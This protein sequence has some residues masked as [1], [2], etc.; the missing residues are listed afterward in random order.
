MMGLQVN[1]KF[2]NDLMSRCQNCSFPHTCAHTS[3]GCSSFSTSQFWKHPVSCQV[4]PKIFLLVFSRAGGSINNSVNDSK[5]TLMQG[6]I[7]AKFA[8]PRLM[9]AHFISALLGIPV[10]MKWSKFHIPLVLNTQTSRHWGE[11]QNANSNYP[12]CSWQY[13]AAAN[14]AKWK[15]KK[16]G[17]LFI[18]NPIYSRRRRKL[19]DLTMRSP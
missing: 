13:L 15:G 3:L 11:G 10:R 9:G 16:G 6:R 19:Q 12:S 14:I 5:K 1:P 8:P 2:T 17:E 7:I 18:Y 4:G